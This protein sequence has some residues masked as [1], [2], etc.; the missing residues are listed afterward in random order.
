MQGWY[1]HYGQSSHEELPV[2]TQQ[3][4]VQDYLIFEDYTG[5]T[6]VVIQ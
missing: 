3:N 2:A 5:I 4:H 6:Y 1:A